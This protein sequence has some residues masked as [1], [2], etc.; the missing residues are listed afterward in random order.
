[1][2]TP[3]QLRRSATSRVI[4]GICGGLAEYFSLDPTVVR[5]I[6]IALTI[7]S[8]GLGGIV[9]YLFAWVIMPAPLGVGGQVR[10]SEGATKALL[11][12]VL[13][14]IGVVVLLM[15]A[16]PWGFG[17]IRPWHWSW[18]WPLLTLRFVTPLILLVLGVILIVVGVSSRSSTSTT[19]EVSQPVAQGVPRTEEAEGERPPVRRLYRSFRNKKIAGICGGLGDYFNVDPTVIRILWI[20]LLILFGTGL[21]LYL[22]LWIVVPQEPIPIPSTTS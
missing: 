12:L 15:M 16:L 22:I 18:H 14:G 5:I 11:G 3:R 8:M 6:W 2:E 7:L 9:L 17:L 21:L 19:G 20:L 1:M 10:N 4:G 13:I